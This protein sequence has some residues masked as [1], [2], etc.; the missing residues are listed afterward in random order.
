MRVSALGSAQQAAVDGCHIFRTASSRYNRIEKVTNRPKASRNCSY[1]TSRKLR[2]RRAKRQLA[3]HRCRCNAPRRAQFHNPA[4]EIFNRSLTA[5]AASSQI[6]QKKRGK[7]K[8]AAQCQD[9]RRCNDN[10]SHLSSKVKGS[11]TIRLLM[12]KMMQISRFR[13]LSSPDLAQIRQQQT[14]KRPNYFFISSTGF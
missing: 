14:I 7:R 8:A 12:H 6:R 9:Y 10:H 13:K 3:A 4:G 1:P 2:E 5:F 11:K